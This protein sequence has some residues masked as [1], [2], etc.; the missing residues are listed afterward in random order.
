MHPRFWDFPAS[1]KYGEIIEG[2]H[3]RLLHGA[4]NDHDT[5]ITEFRRNEFIVYDKEGSEALLF[6]PRSIITRVGMRL[7]H[8]VVE[9]IP[10]NQTSQ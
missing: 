5:S 6:R 4:L 2:R 8:A 3:N 7:Y 1:A 9:L 10:N